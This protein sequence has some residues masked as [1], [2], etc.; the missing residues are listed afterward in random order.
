MWIE[1]GD[2]VQI[3]CGLAI[4]GLLVVRWYLSQTFHD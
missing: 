4:V 1:K 2:R 3:I